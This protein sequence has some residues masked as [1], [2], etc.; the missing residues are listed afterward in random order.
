MASGTTLFDQ[1][2]AEMTRL[3][4]DEPLE[5]HMEEYVVKAKAAGGPV[6]SVRTCRHAWSDISAITGQ[7]VIR[8]GAALRPGCK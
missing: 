6:R 8:N 1:S 2:P 7:I 3:F 4:F 5:T